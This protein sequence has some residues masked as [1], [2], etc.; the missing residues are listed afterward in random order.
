MGPAGRKSSEEAGGLSAAS[1]LRKHGLGAGEKDLQP[2]KWQKRQEENGPGAGIQPGAA[3][4]GV[5]TEISR[6]ELPACPP[7]LLCMSLTYPL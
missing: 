3:G 1:D 5:R 2:F 4:D 7:L 6:D